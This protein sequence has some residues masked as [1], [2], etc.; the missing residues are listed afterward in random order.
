MRASGSLDAVIDAVAHQVH[1]RIA[2]LLQ[3]GLVELGLLAGD[4]QPDLLAEAR[5]QVAH[6]AREAAEHRAHR[7]H[8]HAHDAFLQLADV[9]C[10]AAPDPT[11]SRSACAPSK[12]VAELAEHRLR[13]HDLAHGIQQLVD[14]LDGD[15]DRV[16]FGAGG[17]LAACGRDAGLRPP[18]AAARRSDIRCGRRCCSF[19]HGS[20]P[21]Q[22]APRRADS[23]SIA[24]SQSPSAHSKISSMALA[25]RRRWPARSCQGM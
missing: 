20:G 3:H 14:L 8:A 5:R 6:Q 25:R 9:A 2:D 22:P 4:L 13:D 19:R 21:R 1:Q 12:C 7:Q 18:A 23:D 15:A 11:R 24:S 10:R 17:G 16:D